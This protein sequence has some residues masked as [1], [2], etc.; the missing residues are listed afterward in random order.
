MA[1]GVER[2]IVEFGEG[3]GGRRSHVVHWLVE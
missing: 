3:E 2:V 1:G